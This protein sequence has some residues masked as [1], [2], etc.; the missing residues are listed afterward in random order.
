MNFRIEAI[1][2]ALASPRLM[3]LCSTLAARAQLMGYL[4]ERERARER[5]GIVLDASLLRQIGERAAEAGVGAVSAAALQREGGDEDDLARTLTGLIEAI[6]ESPRPEGEWEPVR[7]LL[8]DD[9]VARLVGGISIS[10]LRRYAAGERR[11]PDD[12]AWRLHLV[13][14]VLSSL[15]GSYNAYGMRRWFERP[16]VQLDGR[17]PVDV[18]SVAEHEDDEWVRRTLTLADALAGAGAA[19]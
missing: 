15:V 11:T 16:R 19:S 4:P 10:S 1:A 7:E 8:G 2:P 14:R 3:A 13:A 6:D 9:L 17:S 18:L 5:D 12:V